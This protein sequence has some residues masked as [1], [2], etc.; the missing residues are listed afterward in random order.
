MWKP[1]WWCTKYSVFNNDVFGYVHIHLGYSSS[2]TTLSAAVLAINL[3]A[4]QVIAKWVE[5]VRQISHRPRI[6]CLQSGGDLIATHICSEDQ[7]FSWENWMMPRK[8]HRHYRYNKT[9][10]C[11]I[12]PYIIIQ[13]NNWLQSLIFLSSWRFV[14]DELSCR[15]SSN[16]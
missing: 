14:S 12:K 10:S 13:A 1:Y 6:H 7:K 16:F 8:Q 9:G 2:V 15:L 5:Q 11:R 4:T 3:S